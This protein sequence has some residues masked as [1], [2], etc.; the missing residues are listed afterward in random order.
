MKLYNRLL[1]IPISVSTPSETGRAIGFVIVGI[2]L[3]IVIWE[4]IKYTKKNNDERAKYRLISESGKDSEKAKEY[5]RKHL[6]HMAI[7][8]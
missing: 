8:G 3:S 4:F 7:A 1:S 6:T 5:D 2:L